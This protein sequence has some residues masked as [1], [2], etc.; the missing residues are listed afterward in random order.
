VIDD[1]APSVQ[2]AS[3]S[4]SSTADSPSFNVTFSE[5]VVGVTLNSFG[6]TGSAKN[7]SFAINEV[8]AGLSYRIVASNCLTGTLA[9]LLP[10]NTVT[11]ATGNLGPLSE[12]SSELVHIDRQPATQVQGVRPKGNSVAATSIREETVDGES[13]P[14]PAFTPSPAREH[15]VVVATPVSSK[16]DAAQTPSPKPWVFAILSAVALVLFVVMLRRRR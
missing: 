14:L 1:G 7:C 2:F 11:D 4:R 8:L 15:S 9:L 3:V 10:A 13:E 5:P 12:T 16:Q 6:R